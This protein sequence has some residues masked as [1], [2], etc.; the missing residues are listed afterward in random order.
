MDLPFFPKSPLNVPFLYMKINALQ[1]SVKIKSTTVLLIGFYQVENIK[2]ETLLNSIKDALGWMDIL[3]MGCKV[4]YYDGAS[5]MVVA[6]TGVAT[7]IS[8]TDS[9]PLWRTATVTLSS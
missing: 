4:Q 2:S 3:L 9:V 8:E 5:N 6:K 7:R 1:E